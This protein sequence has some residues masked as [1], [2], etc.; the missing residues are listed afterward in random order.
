[1]NILYLAHRIPYPPNKGDKIRSFHQIRFL[2]RRHRI[3]LACF[4]DDKEDLRHVDRLKEWCADVRIVFLDRTEGKIRSLMSLLDGRPM[5]VGYYASRSMRAHVDEVL[6]SHGIDAVLIFSSTM[7]QYVMDRPGPGKIMDF[8]DVDSE[9]WMEYA[10]RSGFL[11]RRIYRLEGRRLA[12]YEEKVARA[13]DLSVFSTE[14]E[15]KLFEG[16][17]G[18]SPLAV[19]HNGVDLEYFR[20]NGMVGPHDGPPR[21]VFIGAMDYFPNEDAV[22]YF[23]DEIL[24]RIRESVPDT[25]FDVVGRNPA[26]ALRRRAGRKPGIRV[27][28]N[29]PDIRPYLAGATV[30]VAP[31]RIARGVQNKVL[32]AMAMGVP[33]VATREAHE[34]I[35]AVPGRDL[36]VAE[37]PGEFA[38]HTVRLLKDASERRRLADHAMA[39][40]KER[41]GWEATLADLESALSTLDLPGRR[42]T[43]GRP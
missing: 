43:P 23:I 35:V 31:L 33:V 36:L 6:G 1:M 22:L 26:S 28:G 25:E 10:M 9:K 4:V 37:D 41:Y 29:V 38:R 19:C 8:V 3:F 24:P 34:G 40:V 27:H 14:D 15:R 11:L 20:R 30:S 5:S 39:L 12:A 17:A 16:R 21:L 2:S 32:E 7:A 42:K 13:V 18:R